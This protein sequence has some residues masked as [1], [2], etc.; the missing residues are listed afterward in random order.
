ML[1]VES[2]LRNWQ[3]WYWEQQPVSRMFL[4]RKR[5]ALLQL[6][7][8][9]WNSVSRAMCCTCLQNNLNIWNNFWETT[10]LDICTCTGWYIW[11]IMLIQLNQVTKLV[12]R[13]ITEIYWPIESLVKIQ[14]FRHTSI[15]SI[16][17]PSGLRHEMSSTAQNLWSW[18]GITLKAWMTAC[19]YSVFVLGS[20]LARADSPSKKSYRLS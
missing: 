6:T 5:S 2:V 4:L 15:M 8:E 18:V 3:M 12:L 13:A 1:P 9:S 10:S 7:A 11:R 19:V 14:L 20:G 17:C 16:E